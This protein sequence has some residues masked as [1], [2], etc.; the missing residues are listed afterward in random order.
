MKKA[1]ERCGTE[2]QPRR[3]DRANRF[4]SMACYNASGRPLRR[5]VT[6]LARM[7]RVPGH[8]IAPLSGTVAEHRL[9][10]YDKIG[11]GVHPCEWCEMPVRWIPGDAVSLDAL[12]ADHLDWNHHNNDPANLV[13][14]CRQCNAHR[15][16]GGGR[17]PIRE[18][19]M[20]VVNANGS[21]T[22]AVK[23]DCALCGTEY[24]ARVSQI[25]VGKGI[26]CSPSCARRGP[27]SPKRPSSSA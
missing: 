9:V 3:N 8:P 25:K 1:C 6:V 20:Y 24:L 12:V 19:E 11:P 18:D 26:Y 13:P 4:C 7:R 23:Q 21:R 5:E 2:F 27:R 16:K 17:A 10:L 14:S 22:R 15:V